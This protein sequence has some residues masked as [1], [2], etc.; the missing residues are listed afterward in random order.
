MEICQLSVVI[1]S[2]V[3]Q[4]GTFYGVNK[5]FSFNIGKIKAIFEKLKAVL[6]GLEY[7]LHVYTKF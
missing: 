4:E 5:Y 3:N 6:P 2:F 1:T 7:K